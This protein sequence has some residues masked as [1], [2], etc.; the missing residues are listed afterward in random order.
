[1][2]TT[3]TSFRPFAP[4]LFVAF[5]MMLYGFSETLCFHRVASELDAFA[6]L[7]VV[8]TAC[9]LGT[10]SFGMWLVATI[11]ARLRRKQ[12]SGSKRRATR[13]QH[14]ATA[15]FCGAVAVCACTAPWP[16]ATNYAELKCVAVLTASLF[17]AIPLAVLVELPR[18]WRRAAQAM[19]L[20]GAIHAGVL[21]VGS[22]STAFGPFPVVSMVGVVA[23]VA[24]PQREITP[25][26]GML[27]DSCPAIERPTGVVWIMVDTMR[28]DSF[29]PQ[30]NQILADWAQDSTTFSHAYAPGSATY[31]AFTTW[32]PNLPETAGV[33]FP[34]STTT[35]GATLLPRLF[36]DDIQ[37]EVLADACS[38][39]GAMFVENLQPGA[40]NLF[41]LPTAHAPYDCSESTTSTAEC[42]NESIACISAE[43][44][45]VFDW[46][47]ENPDW[48]VVVTSD[49]GESLGEKHV[50]YHG[51]ALW[52]EQIRV[53]LSVRAPGF[54]SGRTVDTP[55][56]NALIAGNFGC[57]LGD[58][59]TLF[60]GAPEV[61]TG[62]PDPRPLVAHNFVID[63]GVNPA[64]ETAVIDWPY[65]LTVDR[66]TGYE[67]LHH[68]ELDPTESLN[69]AEV[70]TTKVAEMRRTM[71]EVREAPRA[72]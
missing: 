57:W 30:T 50:H 7:R 17:G 13:L 26:T 38:G 3:N 45:A 11:P 4:A 46:A 42:Y 52:Q 48:A 44:E 66:D 27:S 6:L 33:P 35:F 59:P 61:L 25:G 32:L 29:T 22:R 65:K 36:G 12:D 55:V 2:L 14:V 1:M 68:L 60:G 34:I 63:K 23:Q 39:E 56:S 69:L 28:A 70:A 31:T 19:L 43:L 49:H 54:E 37:S 16:F 8:A 15:L 58:D 24:H 62:N 21:G 10:A 20:V 51:S 18:R 40:L 9:L 72:R 67:R 5:T 64:R 71:T 53:P 47:S 41:Y